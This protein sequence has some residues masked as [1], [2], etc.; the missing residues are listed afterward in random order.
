MFF[1]RGCN[2][3]DNNGQRQNLSCIRSI[4][5]NFVDTISGFSILRYPSAD[6]QYGDCS[7]GV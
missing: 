2:I 7:P 1:R 5:L 4:K 6:P 3:Y